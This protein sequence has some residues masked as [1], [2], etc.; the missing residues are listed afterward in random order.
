MRFATLTSTA[1]PMASSAIGAY[2]N[3]LHSSAR[4]F[5]ERSTGS[6]AM[7]LRCEPWRPDRLCPLPP[8]EA[9]GGIKALGGSTLQ[10]IARR[11]KA[12]GR[13]GG[14]QFAQHAIHLV[15]P[16]FGEHRA[17]LV[18]DA[19]GNGDVVVIAHPMRRE[20]GDVHAISGVQLIS[21]SLAL[22]VFLENNAISVTHV[23]CSRSSCETRVRSV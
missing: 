10:A 14:T 7:T 18:I 23:I 16:F 5:V 4:D 13:W 6:M 8:Q 3:A 1:R 15:N 19:Q 17:Q 20:N 9:I 11:G 21:G 12:G 22:P 2:E